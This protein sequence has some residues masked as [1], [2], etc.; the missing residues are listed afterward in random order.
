M[1]G[2]SGGGHAAGIIGQRCTQTLRDD[3]FAGSFAFELLQDRADR[4]GVTAVGRE[5]EIFFVSD[6]GVLQLVDLLIRRT[7]HLINDR[8]AIRE[9]VDCFTQFENSARV[10]ALVFVNA[11]EADVRF[12]LESTTLANRAPKCAD[13]VV[14]KTLFTI[15]ATFDR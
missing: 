2:K 10:V 12:G 5:L 4:G 1:S 14:G 3:L 7:E 6:D 13:R 8:F 15:D 9:L 11:P